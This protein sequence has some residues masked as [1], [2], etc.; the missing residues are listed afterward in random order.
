[1]LPN[2][3]LLLRFFHCLVY[4]LAGSSCH[5]LIALSLFIVVS[6]RLNTL[7]SV[8]NIV[9]TVILLVHNTEVLHDHDKLV[10]NHGTIELR[11]GQ[12]SHQA[13]HFEFLEI[14]DSNFFDALQESAWAKKLQD[15]T[16][17]EHLW[18]SKFRENTAH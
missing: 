14:L 5:F 8:W 9:V 7:L 6:K 16:I 12:D 4:G 3:L 10:Q 11:L 1:M 15:C 18:L 13:S 17:R 2:Y